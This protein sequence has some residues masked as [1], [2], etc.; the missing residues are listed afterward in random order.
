MTSDPSTLR[1]RET[2]SGRPVG[3]YIVKAAE[4][5]P[6]LPLDLSARSPL[7]SM[8]TDADRRVVAEILRV[9]QAGVKRPPRIFDSAE[10]PMTNLRRSVVESEGKLLRAAIRRR[11]A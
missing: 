5:R 11:I 4:S 10:G 6:C 9:K 8:V 1:G 7:P 2:P 3:A